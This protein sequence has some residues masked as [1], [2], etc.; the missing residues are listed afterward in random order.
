VK[1]RDTWAEATVL[2]EDWAKQ[3]DTIA[4]VEMRKDLVQALCTLAE[5]TLHDTCCCGLSEEPAAVR[6]Q[7]LV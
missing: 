1:Q 4:E 5:E 3:L 2:C 6:S 7:A